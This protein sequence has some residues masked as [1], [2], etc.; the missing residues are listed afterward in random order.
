[1]SV[2]L[3]AAV[4]LAIIWWAINAHSYM[5]R[6]VSTQNPESKTASTVASKLETIVIAR[7]GS[8]GP[9]FKGSATYRQYAGTIIR[10]TPTG[11]TFS[12]IWPLSLVCPSFSVPFDQID[13]RRTSWAMWDEP[14]ALR[15][16][17]QPEYDVIVSRDTVQW[18]RSLTDQK[19]FRTEQ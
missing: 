3:G 13:L 6:F 7:R 11:L 16:R 8:S 18:V 15:L 5:W 19:P 9:S 1:M 17:N 14:F 12:A 10:I 4:F 2:L